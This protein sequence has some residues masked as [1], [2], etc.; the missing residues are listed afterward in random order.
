MELGTDARLRLN[1]DLW[2]I[3]DEALPPS[4]PDFSVEFT[5]DETVIKFK[6]PFLP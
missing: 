3:V 4:R 6:F 5:G 2:R 1:L